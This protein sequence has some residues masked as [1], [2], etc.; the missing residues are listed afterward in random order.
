MYSSLV[1]ILAVRD[2]EITVKTADTYHISEVTCYGN[3]SSLVSCAHS[4]WESPIQC[5]AGLVH[6]ECVGKSSIV[7]S[8]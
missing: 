6:L 4:D 5:Q 8:L 1:D 3:E 2:I 7:V